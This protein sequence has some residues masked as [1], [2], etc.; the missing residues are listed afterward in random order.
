MKTIEVFMLCIMKPFF[1][2]IKIYEW[3]EKK[4]IIVFRMVLLCVVFVVCLAVVSS[5][6]SFWESLVI[7]IGMIWGA[8]FFLSFFSS[9]FMKSKRLN[10]LAREFM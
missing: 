5:L 8:L 7:R 6:P 1:M 4:A 2:A 3:F 10:D 9:L